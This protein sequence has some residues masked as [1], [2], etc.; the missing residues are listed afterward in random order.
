MNPRATHGNCLPDPAR[1]A[2]TRDAPS[3]YLGAW[4]W[5]LD[6][7]SPFRVQYA[8]LGAM[9]AVIFG[10]QK[11]SLLAAL[12]VA[13][14][15]ANLPPII[16]QFVGPASAAPTTRGARSECCPS[17]SSSTATSISGWCSSSANNLPDVLILMEVTP[18]WAQALDGL[19][20]QY[21]FRWVN[22]G[23]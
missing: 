4:S 10:A 14:L 21:A 22:P 16:P 11:R 17:T 6:L 18:A 23:R 12:S 13:T 2:G 15:L 19:A 9:L 8:V 20:A 3:A 7:F 5:F 1:C